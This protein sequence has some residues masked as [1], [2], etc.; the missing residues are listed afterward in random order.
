LDRSSFKK[1]AKGKFRGWMRKE[2]FDLL[3]TPFFEDPVPAIQNLEGE[4]IKASKL[5]F[6]AIFPLTDGRRIFFKRDKTQGLLVSL[7][8]LMLPSKGRKEWFIADQLK[9]RNLSVPEPLGW[10]EKVHRGFVKESYYLSEA[11]GSGVSLIEDSV[12]LGSP[13]ALPNLAKTL[14]KFHDAGLF[15]HDL[16]AGNFLRDGESFYLTDLHRAEIVRSLSLDQRLWNFSQLFLSLRSRWTEK[17]QMQFIEKYFEGDSF[18]LKQKE[19]HI[20]K[21]HS[22]MDRLQKRHWRSRTKRCVKESTEFSMKKKEGVR[23]YHRRDFSL[24]DIRRVIGEHLS[25]VREKPE[26]LAKYS[27]EVIVSILNVG[28]MRVCVKQFR[29][30]HVRDI[31]KDLFR[32]SKGL[33]SWVGGNG[34]KVRGISSIKPIALVEKRGW[35]GGRESFFLMEA[36]EDAKELD[37]SILLWCKGFREKRLFIKAFAQWFSHFHQMNLYHK[38]MKTRNI[39]FSKNG[40]NLNFQLLDL[41]DIRLDEKINEKKLFKNL[42]QLNTSVPTIFTRTDRL[43]FFKGYLR[44]NPIIKDRKIFLRRLI[45]ESQRRGTVYVTPEGVI[46]KIT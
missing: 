8:L 40:E 31:F 39:L 4:V 3:P 24:D 25:L 10:M 16:H 36:P 6:A 18:D 13:L 43:R 2:I 12:I 41:E 23:Y 29:Y 34:L 33:K 9:K 5:R 37:R 27:S 11:I 21:I 38:D 46:I 7:K 19:E 35:L 44:L 15:H 17:E 20:R 28:G 30:P 26:A 1:I 32:P 14:R 22:L 45:E 42:L